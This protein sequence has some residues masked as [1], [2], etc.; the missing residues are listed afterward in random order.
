[1]N[2]RSTPLPGV[3][4]IEPRRFEDA[5]GYFYESF[6]PAVMGALGCPAT[7]VQDNVSGSKCGVL[8]GL[9]YQIE[10]LAQGK[11]VRVMRGRV[12]DAVVDLRRSSPTFGRPYVIE[13]SDSNRIHLW[14]PPGLAHGFCVLSEFAEVIY[15]VTR[16]YS[17]AHERTLRWDD[18][19]LA[20][21]WPT[22]PAGGFLLSEKDRAG[23]AL[24][25]AEINFAL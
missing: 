11:L 24:S 5:R 22:P 3:K 2:V 13:L 1:M 17:P 4:L 8:R 18:R 7:F 25:D 15:S 6:S 12:L 10:P 19:A 14:V 23:V 9:H 16:P 21:D 20:I